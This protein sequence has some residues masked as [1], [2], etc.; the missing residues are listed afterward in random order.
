MLAANSGLLSAH[1]PGRL[2]GAAGFSNDHCN[3]VTRNRVWIY[4]CRMPVAVLARNLTVE[5][6][7]AIH[8]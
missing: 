6:P 2:T 3:H 5:L 1:A 7:V 8:V 4:R